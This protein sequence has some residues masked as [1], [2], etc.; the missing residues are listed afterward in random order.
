MEKLIIKIQKTNEGLAMICEEDFNVANAQAIKEALLE[1]VER[2][3]NEILSLVTATTI[4]ASGIQ[5]AFVWKKALEAQGRRA[6][7]LFPN[8]EN[9]KELLDKT[10]IT[11]IF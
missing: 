9:S 1:S 2:K 6:D 7:V 4:D 5:L 8:S 3:G 11:Q 10:G